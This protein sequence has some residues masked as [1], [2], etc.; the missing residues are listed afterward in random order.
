M[1]YPIKSYSRQELNKISSPGKVVPTLFW[2]IP[3]GARI[4]LLIRSPISGLPFNFTISLKVEPLGI[5]INYKKFNS[6][7][8]N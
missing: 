1:G 5:V 2:L 6:L 7:Y 3:I 8:Y 4:F